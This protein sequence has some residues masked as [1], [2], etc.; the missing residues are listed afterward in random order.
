MLKTVSATIRQWGS[1]L[2]HPQDAYRDI[3]GRKFEK[4]VEEYMI[5]LILVAAAAA[6]ASFLYA[7]G[8]ALYLNI[9]YVVDIQYL[10]M[11]N[12]ALGRATSLLFFYFFAGT[13]LIFFISLVLRPFFRHVKYTQLITMLLYA[14]SPLL[15]FGWLPISL[16]AFFIWCVAIFVIGA[17][18][19]PRREQ[20]VR[21]D[22]I[23]QRD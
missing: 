16:V 17:R 7:L 15:L 12:Y 5:M 21:K 10:R 1:I 20:K 4:V 14:A 22:S 3:P 9:A 18:A 6:V 2:A 19:M 11:M 13:F 23:A 8:N